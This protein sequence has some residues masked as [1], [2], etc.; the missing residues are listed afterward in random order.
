M[1]WLKSVFTVEVRGWVYRVLIAVG[2][3]LAAYGVVSADELAVWLGVVV[4]VL[5]V[6]PSANTPVRAVDKDSGSDI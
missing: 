3:L 1:S 5:N 2:A 6:M 4:A